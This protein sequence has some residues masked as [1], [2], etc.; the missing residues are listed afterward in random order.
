MK[1]DISSFAMSRVRDRPRDG[2]MPEDR[3]TRDFFILTQVSRSSGIS[4][5]LGLSRTRDIAKEK[6]LS[7]RVIRDFK[8]PESTRELGLMEPECKLYSTGSGVLSSIFN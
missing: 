4:P 7:R 6:I 1:P 2:D 5:S 3:D 8:S